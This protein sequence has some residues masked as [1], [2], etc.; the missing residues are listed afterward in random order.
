MLMGILTRAVEMSERKERRNRMGGRK[1]VKVAE[2]Y[3]SGIR[4]GAPHMGDA[5]EGQR[6]N[7]GR[8]KCEQPVYA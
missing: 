4:A 3:G 5:A 6:G 7:R 2:K 1:K 8:V